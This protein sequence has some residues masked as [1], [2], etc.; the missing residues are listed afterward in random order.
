MFSVVQLMLAVVARCS[1]RCVQFLVSTR[2]RR[3]KA[4]QDEQI[5]SMLSPEDKITPRQYEISRNDD[6]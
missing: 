5:F 1:T 6:E 2:A 4:E 3:S